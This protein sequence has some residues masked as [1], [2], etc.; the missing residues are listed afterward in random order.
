MP[1]TAE[2]GYSG[3]HSCTSETATKLVTK[4]TVSTTETGN[5][6]PSTLHMEAH[7]M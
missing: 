7:A 5:A 1:H 2:V 6:I 4:E 3:E